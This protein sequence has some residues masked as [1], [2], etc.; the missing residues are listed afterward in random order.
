[1]SEEPIYRPHPEPVVLDIGGANG[2]L[3]VYADGSLIDTPI[4]ISPADD[5]DAKVHQH[6]LERPMPEDTSYAAVFDKVTEGA[7]TLWL[8]GEARVRDV[9]ITGG[10]VTQVDWTSATTSTA[11]GTA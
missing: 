6:V 5:D 2:A 9:L 10:A 8:Y 1:M 11:A 4:E 3:V 7:Y